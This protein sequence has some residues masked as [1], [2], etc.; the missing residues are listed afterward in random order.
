MTFIAE[1]SRES[2]RGKVLIATGYV[3]QQ[4]RNVLAAF[5]VDGVD[6]QACSMGE[7]LR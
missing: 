5:M 3:E 7:A 4:L 1:L 2:D 6:A